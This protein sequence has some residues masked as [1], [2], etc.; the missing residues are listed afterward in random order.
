LIRG[1]TRFRWRKTAVLKPVFITGNGR[2]TCFS[3]P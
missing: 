3:V 2:I 1:Q